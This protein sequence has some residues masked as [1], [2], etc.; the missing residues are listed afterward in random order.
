MRFIPFLALLTT[1]VFADPNHYSFTVRKLAYDG[2]RKTTYVLIH[3]SE[4]GSSLQ[5]RRAFPI[6]GKLAQFGGM[7]ET[8]GDKGFVS[9]A[10]LEGWQKVNAS[11]L[12]VGADG[13]VFVGGKLSNFYK[14]TLLKGIRAEDYRRDLRALQAGNTPDLT[15]AQREE[16]VMAATLAL[17]RAG[18]HQDRGVKALEKKRDFPAKLFVSKIAPSGNLAEF[19]DSGTQIVHGVFESPEDYLSTMHVSEKGEITFAAEIAKGRDRADMVL[20]RL[21]VEGPLQPDFGKAGLAR[22]SHSYLPH[23]KGSVSWQAEDIQPTLA[24]WRVIATSFDG[25]SGGMHRLLQLD[26]DSNARHKPSLEKLPTIR[27]RF[28]DTGFPLDT[29]LYTAL[30]KNGDSLWM[31]GYQHGRQRIVVHKQNLDSKGPLTRLVINEDLRPKTLHLEP[32]GELTII[33]TGA[34]LH[35]PHSRTI[36]AD[37]KQVIDH[38]VIFSNRVFAGNP[39]MPSDCDERFIAL[40]RKF[41]EPKK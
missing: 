41:L 21:S 22:V 40:L 23:V 24:G 37:G 14:P 3:V 15:P 17:L 33:A 26:F 6:V 16:L 38:P 39:S 30:S 36:S 11:D 34:G 18:A 1:P 19:G 2:Q 7:E 10:G 20:G 12:K 28:P 31:V 13:S 27:Y 25:K 9:L 5:L 4:F 29:D 8:F 32:G 35:R